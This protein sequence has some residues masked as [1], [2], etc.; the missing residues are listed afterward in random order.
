MKKLFLLLGL[1][2]PT[3]ILAQSQFR[4]WRGICF[5]AGKLANYFGAAGGR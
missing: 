2:I 5:S 4:R 3:L 1:L